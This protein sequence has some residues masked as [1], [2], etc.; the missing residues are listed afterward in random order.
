MALLKI[1]ATTF[2]VTNKNNSGVGSLRQ[3]IIDANADGT[4]TIN[5]P[6]IIDATAISDTVKLLSALPNINNHITINGGSSGIQFAV[7]GENLYRIFYV[8]SGK[9]FTLNY[10]FIINGH[11][12]ALTDGA[13]IDNFGT[14]V[15]NNCVV[16]NNNASRYGGGIN[17]EPNA[18]CFINNSTLTNN[19]SINY[20]GGALQSD[21][22]VNIKNSLISGN[23][24][25]EGG[26]LSLGG[27]SGAMDT[28]MNCSVINNTGFEGAGIF[29]PGGIDNCV[30]INC[31]ISNNFSNSNLLEQNA[32]GITY[33]GN[34]LLID[35][36]TLS[37]NSG[38]FSNNSRGGGLY[39]ATDNVTITRTTFNGNKS[40]QGGALASIGN[41]VTITNCT[42]NTDSAS[43][44]NGGSI[45]VE[46]GSMTVTNSTF[47]GNVASGTG[48][49]IY[50]TA[51]TIKINNALI[52]GNTASGGTDISG[53]I[54]SDNGHNLIGNTTGGTLTGTTT[55]NVTG[56]A[57]SAVL[58]T[59]LAN[60]GGLTKTHALIAGSPAIDAGTATGAPTTDQRGNTRIGQV[61]IGSY[62]ASIISS[63]LTPDARFTSSAPGCLSQL[64]NFYSVITET[65][66]VTHSWDFGVGA[67]P[68][69]SLA[70]DP[71]GIIYSSSGAK[72]I[73]HIV[74]NGTTADTVTNIITINPVPSVS[75]TSTA[76]AC[77]GGTVNF[78]NTGSSGIGY[79]YNW[80]LGDDA[81]PVNSGAQ[82][83]VG[84]EYSSA[85][86][87]T[88]TQYIT[89]QFGCT[90]ILTKTISID[91]LPVADAGMDTT[92][93]ANTT[94]QIGSAAVA[95]N[96][97]SWFPVSI[98][99]SASVS[100]PVASPTAPNTQLIVTVNNA[101]T[102]CINHDTTYVTMLPPIKANAG[103]D[104]AICKND[105]V[106]IGS[107][108]VQ[109]QTYSWDPLNG[110]SN[111]TDPSPTAQPSITTTYTVSVFLYG[112]GPVTDDVTVIVHPLPLANAGVD[113]TITT[114]N[115][116]Q[117]VATGGIQ[118]V[119]TPAFS[120]S[121]AGI[122]DPVA[123]PE[124]ATDYIVTVTDLNNCVN[125][126]T[127]HISVLEPLY[128]LPN[129]FTPGNNGLNDVFYVRG[130]GIANFEFTV[131]DRW[132]A[133]IFY[134]KDM[135]TGWDGTKQGTDKKMP[136]GAY[137]FI[138]RGILSNGEIINNKG[139]VN[140]IR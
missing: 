136:E 82:N 62:E 99:N 22:L 23:T 74:S 112:C 45:Y 27:L 92:I 3:A 52:V 60:N 96:S 104:V 43:T 125:Y 120:L 86:T 67:T 64:E 124:T 59:T 94:V 42:F 102:G 53:T 93:C 66:G 122:N 16:N 137:V 89:N 71:A 110:L 11:T 5:S 63:T 34:S 69:I 127:V 47:Y 83:P 2:S 65:V 140:L 30:M 126:D 80:D 50:R 119:W 55:G 128:W 90:T 105:S 78:T 61:D 19:T 8:A 33:G 87:K 76:P 41:N 70:K 106:Q 20:A 14:L 98:L 17:N 130:R 24:S 44:G 38:G 57:A 111:A 109:G 25:Y 56:Y 46:G 123:H 37:N 114:G 51:G 116:V 101:T 1:E 54:N 35:G 95:G 115:S 79:V 12:F 81:M 117:L 7:S 129:S 32:G 29:I 18:S 138:V 134:S 118:Y 9:K 133:Q 131:F 31:I 88:I 49:A 84:I 10:V 139:L 77:I 103:I 36:C 26:G 113:D 28:I 39:I 85:G 75:F 132:G 4:A 108:L 21:G 107:A 91:P 13:G 48:G 72:L 6:H 121:N 135:N 40:K 15:V 97:Y 100:D 73:T 68:P 58:N